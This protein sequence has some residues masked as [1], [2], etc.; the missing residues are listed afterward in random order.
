M[1][2]ITSSTTYYSIVALVFIRYCLHHFDDFFSSSNTTANHRVVFLPSNTI[3]LSRRFICL[4]ENQRAYTPHLILSLNLLIVG[5]KD[6]VKSTLYSKRSIEYLKY[7]E[8]WPKYIVIQF[9]YAVLTTDCRYL[10]LFF[11]LLEDFTEKILL[12]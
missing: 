10:K 2:R 9:I 8:T 7:S 5:T 4:R 12:F 11:K 6:E 1:L 3:L